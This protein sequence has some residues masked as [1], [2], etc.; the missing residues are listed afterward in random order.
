MTRNPCNWNVDRW[1][2]EAKEMTVTI[3]VVLL[4]LLT[5]SLLLQQELVR[6]Y[7]GGV[8]G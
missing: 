4:A 7:K 5:V 1:A 6:G 2:K 8:L 3:S